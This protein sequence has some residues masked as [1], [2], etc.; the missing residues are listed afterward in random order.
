MSVITSGNHPKLQWP[1]IH[2]L[3]GLKYNEHAKEYNDLFE[4]DTSDKSYEEIVENIGFGLA[5]V[6]PQGAS[7]AYDITTQGVV[8]RATHVAYALGY[9][10]TYEEMADNLYFRKSKERAASNAFSMNQTKEY[11]FANAYNRAFSGSYVFGDAVALL[12]ASHPTAAGV[13]SNLLTTA[14]DLSEA[15]L[16][17][18]TIQIMQAKNSRGLL[19]GLKPKTLHIAPSNYYNAE[20]IL[21]TTLVT[22]TANNDINV[23][24][25]NNV[26]PGGAKVNHF[27]TDADAWFL[28]TDCPTSMIAFQRE[29]I[30]FAQDNDFDTKNAKAAAYERYSYT[31]GDWRGL[32]GSPGA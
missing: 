19:I 12:S 8:N 2:A 16:E 10:V 11:V 26:I 25:R 1:G 22:G 31:I 32:F 4:F 29:A 30:S 15:S 13:Q 21:K 20:R 9:I 24:N 6:K 14:A 5:P 3:W 7:V 28:R 23:I 17:D 27:F 18:M